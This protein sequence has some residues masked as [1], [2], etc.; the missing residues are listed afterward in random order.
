MFK[1]SAVCVHFR[2]GLLPNN[3]TL[4]IVFGATLEVVPS[5]L[6]CSSA[7]G[8]ASLIAYK[9]PPFAVWRMSCPVNG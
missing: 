1:L 5:V 9:S 4:L 8:F 7:T 6:M 3:S 2:R